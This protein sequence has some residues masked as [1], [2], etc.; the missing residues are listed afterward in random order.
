MGDV[1]KTNVPLYIYIYMKCILH[2][3]KIQNHRSS[4]VKGILQGH[5]RKYLGNKEAKQKN[6]KGALRGKEGIEGSRAFPIYVYIF[7]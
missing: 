7:I 4:I 1:Q 6:I 5:F 2:E 3:L